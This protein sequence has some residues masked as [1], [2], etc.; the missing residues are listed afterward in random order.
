MHLLG[1]RN[2]TR[3]FLFMMRSLLKLRTTLQ[4]WNYAYHLNKE[5]KVQTVAVKKFSS[6]SQFRFKA[7]A[8][9]H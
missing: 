9:F 4:G 7:Q 2:S 5:A 3:C 8:L 1:I 6:T